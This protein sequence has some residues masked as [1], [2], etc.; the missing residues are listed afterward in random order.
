MFCI[1]KCT[2]GDRIIN[3]N[4][5]SV[6]NIKILL[7]VEKNLNVTSRRNTHTVHYFVCVKY[8]YFCKYYV[9]VSITSFADE[10]KSLFKFF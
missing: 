6:N 2:S 10:K 3:Y 1:A 4:N 9:T 7:S 5:L 8:G